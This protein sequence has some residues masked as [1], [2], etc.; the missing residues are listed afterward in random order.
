VSEATDG[1]SQKRPATFLRGHRPQL[2]TTRL[3]FFRVTSGAIPFCTPVNTIY[4][5]MKTNS[6]NITIAIICGLL[7]ILSA[8]FAFAQYEQTNL[9]G[10]VASQGARFV[11]PNLNGWGMDFAPDGSICVANTA[12]GVATFYNPHSGK[13]KKLIITIPPGANPRFGPVGSPTGVVYN[14][15]HHFVISAHGKSAPAVFIFDTL[16]GTISGWNPEV[17]PTNAII[18]VDN[19]AE[20]PYPGDY[21]G[22]TLGRNSHGKIVLYA[23]DSGDS[24]TISNNRIDMFDGHFHKI[25]SFT[26]AN[27]PFPGNTVFQAENLEGRIFVTFATFTAPF[28]GI[29][30]IFDTDGNLLTP[31]HW[32][33]NGFNTGPLVNPWAIVR[34]P[35]SFGPFGNAILIGNVEDGRISAFND[36][37]HFLGQ[38]KDRHGN[39]IAITGL[40]DLVFGQ[41]GKAGKTDELYF[42]AGPDAEDFA[43][44]G[45]FGVISPPDED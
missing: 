26:D 43:G 29:I 2:Q 19:S 40:W 23:C 45:L 25:G 11:D 18:M 33:I 44:D 31:N 36:H 34:A 24:A 5:I 22:L 6:R 1:V 3:S 39:P 16:D 37:G 38:L 14:S 42:A 27:I 21:T 15:T 10:Y 13:P 12:T 17:D 41:G 32:A 35:R 8:G 4:K 20:T 9:V 28:D 7:L 30:D